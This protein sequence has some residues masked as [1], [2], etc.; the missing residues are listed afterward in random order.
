MAAVFDQVMDRVTRQYLQILSSD[1]AEH[2]EAEKSRLRQAQEAWEVFR[3]ANCE[4]TL[5]SGF[6]PE[7]TMYSVGVWQCMTNMTRR[8]TEELRDYLRR[9]PIPESPDAS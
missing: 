3:K 5:E 9:M 1:A 4:T 6:D 2:A 8:R 7:G